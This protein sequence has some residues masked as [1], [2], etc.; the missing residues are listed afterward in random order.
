M[1]KHRHNLLGTAQVSVAVIFLTSKLGVI[2]FNFGWI[3]NILTFFPMFL[4]SLHVDVGI[5]PRVGYNL[6]SKT[7]FN[8]WTPGRG[9][10]VN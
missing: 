2:C 10:S 3:T 8:W 6:S 7:P 4:Q 1:A 5:V 9:L